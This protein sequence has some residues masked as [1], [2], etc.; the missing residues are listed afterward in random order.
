M[1]AH[2]F[3][4]RVCN[5]SLFNH[6]R[7]TANIAGQ[8]ELLVSFDQRISCRLATSRVRQRG[9]N[10]D[11]ASKGRY[12]L[13]ISVIHTTVFIQDDNAVRLAL[14]NCGQILLQLFVA[15]LRL[16]FGFI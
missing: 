13:R 3:E 1:G 9:A 6:H 4:E 16:F 10:S 2:E 7:L 14:K 8:F 15:N 11:A 5:S 12:C